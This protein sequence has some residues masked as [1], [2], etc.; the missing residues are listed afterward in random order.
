MPQLWTE[1][2][3]SQYFWLIVI[4]VTFNSFFVNKVV[5]SIAKNIKA[6]KKTG[7]IVK[8][9]LQSKSLN[10]NVTLPDVISTLSSQIS[11]NREVDFNL[12]D[13]EED[14]DRTRPEVS[15]DTLTRQ[16]RED[17]LEVLK[18][19]EFNFSKFFSWNGGRI[20]LEVSKSQ[21]WL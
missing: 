11:T 2:F 17:I 20:A 7:K 6:R 1:T 8:S 16:E 13:L 19:K 14:I 4:L 12:I 9:D 18:T 10:V 3:V 21:G 5:P 15:E